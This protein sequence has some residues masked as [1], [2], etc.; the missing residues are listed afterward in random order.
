MLCLFLTSASLHAQSLQKKLAPKQTVKPAP[1]F[2]LVALDGS[3]VN[4]KA[5]DGKVVIL[6]FWA[7][8]CPPCRAEIP[9]FVALQKKYAGKVQVVGISLDDDAKPVHPFIKEQGINYPIAMGDEDIVKAFG[10]IQGIP[11]TFVIDKKRR[12]VAKFVGYQD[13][14]TFEKTLAPLLK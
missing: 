6:D 11:T 8:W 12:I 4:L 7:T 13:L 2:S 9:H 10:G 14:S 3:P 1:A 5:Y